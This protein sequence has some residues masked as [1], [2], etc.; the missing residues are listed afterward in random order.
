[1]TDRLIPGPSDLMMQ[2]LQMSG[3]QDYDLRRPALPPK[4]LHAE[5]TD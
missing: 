4:L 2:F 1:L 3:S 5:A